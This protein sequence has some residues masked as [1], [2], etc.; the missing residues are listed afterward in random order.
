MYADNTLTPREVVRLGALGLLMEEPRR[1]AAVAQ[2]VRHFIAHIMG[3]SLELLGTSIELLLY[4]GLVDAAEGT[5]MTDDALLAITAE[6]RTEFARLMAARVRATAD[7][8]K[9]IVALKF[10]FM[11]LLPPEEQSHQMDV[12]AESYEEE[13]DRLQELRDHHQGGADDPLSGWLALDLALVEQRLAWLEDWRTRADR[14][15]WD[16]ILGSH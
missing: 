9:L 16:P 3:P 11:A 8:S 15:Q 12:L 4:E 2:E 14:G 7:I 1:Y 6:G 10:R 5:G 13:R